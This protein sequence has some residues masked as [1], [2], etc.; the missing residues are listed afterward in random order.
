MRPRQNL[1]PITA[2]DTHGKTPW[3][4]SRRALK[5][6]TDRVEIPCTCHYCRGLVEIRHHQ[7]IY[8][9]RQFGEWPWVYACND[10]DAYVGMHPFTNLPLGTLASAETRAARNKAKAA[11]TQ[12]WESHRMTRNQGY[13]WLAKQLGI[14]KSKCHIGWSDTAQCERII[15]IC[16]GAV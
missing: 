7:E 15:Q 11:F 9:G 2:A 4:P 1:P 14:E 3:N 12:Y 16:Q 10:C 5:R 13:I 6:V 8:N